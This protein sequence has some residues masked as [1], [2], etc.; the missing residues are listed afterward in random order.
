MQLN[1]HVVQIQLAVHFRVAWRPGWQSPV[2]K[3]RVITAD[4][5]PPPFPSPHCDIYVSGSR[6]GHN[7][8][9]DLIGENVYRNYYM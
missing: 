5:F 1:L 6:S 2:S 8:R 9:E 4:V 7:I 3:I